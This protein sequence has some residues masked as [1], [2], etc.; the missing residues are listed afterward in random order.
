MILSA[1]L[2]CLAAVIYFE[3]GNQPVAGK[4]AVGQVVLNRV[5]SRHFP[6]TICGVI[7]QKKQFSFFW[8]G[9][10][11]IV[12]RNS[13]EQEQ[14]EVSR[15]VAYSLINGIVSDKTGGAT[16]YHSTA[17]SPYWIRSVVMTNR[18][19]NHIFYRR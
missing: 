9:K 7:K 18:I 8:D 11:E 13:I 6:N 1:P 16:Y 12:K 10:R 14:W 19:G 2:I 5:A 15:I 17:V 3:A 4:Y